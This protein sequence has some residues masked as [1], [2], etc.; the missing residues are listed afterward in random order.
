MAK[1]EGAPDH[2]APRNADGNTEQASSYTISAEVATKTTSRRLKRPALK[3]PKRSSTKSSVRELALYDGQVCL[4]LVKIAGKVTAF[5][6]DGER[7]GTFTSLQDATDA[8]DKLLT[9]EGGA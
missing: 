1:S 8:L 2:G 6:P 4:G 3:S 9:V 7:V 5:S